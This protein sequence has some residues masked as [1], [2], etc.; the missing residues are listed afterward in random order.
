MKYLILAALGILTS[1]LELEQSVTIRADGS[2]TQKMTLGLTRR[3]IASLGRSLQARNPLDGV[4]PLLVF[5]EELVA[6]ELRERGMVLRSHRTWNARRHRFVE[7]EAD[8]GSL[9][10]LKKSPL[11]GSNAEWLVVPGKGKWRGNLRLIFYPQGRVAW[12]KA[13]Q[14]VEDLKGQG[15]AVVQ[16]FFERR[17]KEMKGLD[18]ALHIEVPGDVVWTHNLEREGVRKVTARVTEASIQT[19]EDLIQVL[20]PRYEVIFD[21]RGCSW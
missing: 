1:C 7:L 15:D 10:A 9:A 2:G 8:F 12:Q 4:D 6:E 14:Q 11:A 20:A 17:R 16:S 18:I 13:R 5:E 19:P 3:V 21:G